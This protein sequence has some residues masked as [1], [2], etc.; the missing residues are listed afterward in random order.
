MA[1]SFSTLNTTLP[2]IIAHRGYSSKY[3]ENTLSAFEAALNVGVDMIELDVTLTADEHIVVIH[4]DTLDRTTNG[5]GYVQ[6]SSLKKIKELD[7]GQWF[8]PQFKGETVPTLTEVLA[9]VKDSVGLNIELKPEAYATSSAPHTI[10]NQICRL[11]KQWKLDHSVLISS[12]QHHF[13]SRINKICPALKTA[14]LYDK[15]DTA[16][17]I[18]HWSSEQVFACHPGQQSLRR[19]QVKELQQKGLKV[20]PYTVDDIS[21]M[22]KLINWGVDGIFTNEPEKL[23]QVITEFKGKGKN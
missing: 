19:Y 13:I 3:P 22:E 17:V 2:I 1:F 8:S 12:F 6:Q 9:L 20:H 16:D 21:E 7:A 10:E 23:R 11:V 14:L 15:F 18:N 5:Q 4:D